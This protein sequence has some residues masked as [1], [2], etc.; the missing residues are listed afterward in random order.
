MQSI[1]TPTLS[2]YR[3]T[4]LNPH[5]NITKRVLVNAYHARN[6][7][8]LALYDVARVLNTDSEELEISQI[9]KL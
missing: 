9:S 8:L 3:I 1:T 6:A 2:T 7:E 5:T 4:V